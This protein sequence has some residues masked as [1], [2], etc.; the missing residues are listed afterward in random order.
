MLEKEINESFGEYIIRL[1]NAKGYSQ[2]KLALITGISNTTIN[3]IERGETTSPDLNT[4]KLL[5]KYLGVDEIYMLHASGY[6]DN[7]QKKRANIDYSL[8]NDFI[9]SDKIMETTENLTN[10]NKKDIA[11]ELERVKKS[12]MENQD[13]LM[14]DGEPASEEAIQS[15]LDA[16][17]FGM[18]Q[19]KIIN[20]KYIPKKHRK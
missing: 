4:I 10:K 12:I 6:I 13:G 1:R 15:V 20:K 9:D 11:K 3:R 19:A 14:F 5:S 8:N 17:E 2:R 16:L 18:K 7:P